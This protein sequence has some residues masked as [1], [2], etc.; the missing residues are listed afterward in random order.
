MS[1]PSKQ[2]TEND[3]DP[4]AA[5]S[6]NSTLEDSGKLLLRLA[7]AGLM[8]F[9]GIAKLKGLD[10]IEKMLEGAGLPLFLAYGVY[11]GE[12]IAPLLMIVGFWTRIAS[13]VFAFNMLVAILLGHGNELLSLNQYGGWA[14]ELPMLFML[15][16]VSIALIGSGRF[17]V[18]PS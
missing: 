16:A 10:G 18:K 13:L 14:I 5:S 4:T 1:D 12:L 6:R 2:D 17:A 7:V 8:L 11:V 9:H 15:A 3:R